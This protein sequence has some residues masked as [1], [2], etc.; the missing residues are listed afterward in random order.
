MFNGLRFFEVLLWEGWWVKFICGVS[1]EVSDF[2]ILFI[3]FD[4]DGI[5]SFWNGICFCKYLK[6]F[7][8]MLKYI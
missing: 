2:G 7:L 6:I 4:C 5:I 3:K 8:E 1:F